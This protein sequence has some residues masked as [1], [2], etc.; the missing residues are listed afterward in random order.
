MGNW[1]SNVWERLFGEK[2]ELK[3]VIVGLDAAGKTT[4]INQMRFNEFGQTA[5][6]I[7]VNTEDIQIKNVN[8]K[9]FDLAGQ[10]KMRNVWKYY[11][12]SIEGIIFV[13][14]ATRT[15]RVQDARDE[16]LSLLANEEAKHIPVLVFA[17]KQDLPSALK[18]NEIIDLLGIGDYVNKKPMSIVRVQEASAKLDQGLLEGF[19]WIVDKIIQLGVAR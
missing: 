6:T 5:P 4:I 11:Y 1:F 16:L 15:D 9:V 13:L 3:L 8:I 7:G 19:E 2:R 18:S 10:E 17:N 12:S 14:D